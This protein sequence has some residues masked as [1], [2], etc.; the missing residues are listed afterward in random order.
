KVAVL[1]PDE[2]GKVL[3]TAPAGAGIDIIS[4]GPRLHHLYVPGARAATLTIF[5]VSPTGALNALAVYKTAEHAHCVTD[6]NAGH[7]FVCDPHAGEIFK[8]DDR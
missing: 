3:A 5:N 7:V 6:D 4:Y 8:I 1:S 2:H